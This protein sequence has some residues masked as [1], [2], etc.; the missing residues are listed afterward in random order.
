VERLRHSDLERVVRFSGD[1][2]AAED[3]D[4]FSPRLLESFRKLVGSDSASYCELDRPGRRL[5]ANT[6]VPEVDGSDDNVEI[7]WRLR[8]QHPHC[9]YEDRTGD[10]STRKL[11]DFVSMRDQRRL[12]I[13]TEFFRPYDVEYEIG[14]GLPAPLTHTKVFIFGNSP[15]RGDFRERE[16]TVLELVRPHL[17]RRYQQV[18]ARRRAETAVAALDTCEEALVLLD[19]AGRAEFA[20]PRALRLLAAHG[21]DLTD[22]PEVEP[23]VAQLVRPDVL[24]LAERRPFGLTTREREILALVAEGRSNAEV[25]AA[26]WISP[27]TVGKHLENAYAK[28]GVATRTAAVQR[29]REYGAIACNESRSA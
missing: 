6:G 15:Q 26:L 10:F 28:L 22:V 27:G 17:V 20:T 2:A 13:Y 16:R 18:H 9:A 25:A 3:A 1:L 7:Y 4:P 21:L 19:A 24:L 12:E 8:H 14:V 11:T 23:L 5:L 29:A